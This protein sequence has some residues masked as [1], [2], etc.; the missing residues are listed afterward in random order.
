MVNTGADILP[1]GVTSV[2]SSPLR[3]GTAKTECVHFWYHMGGVDPGETPAHTEKHQTCLKNDRKTQYDVYVR[4]LQ[5]IWQYMWRWW[6][7]RGWRSS[8]TV[9]TRETS[10]AMATETSRL[11]LW[12]GRY[13][14]EAGEGR[15]SNYRL[16]KWSVRTQVIS[17]CIKKSFM[18]WLFKCSLKKIFMNI[19]NMQIHIVF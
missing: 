15:W 9:W 8:L 11:A 16:F 3:H 14:V 18:E 7:E 2:L 19:I 4:G 5:V 12:T 17:L 1:S 10:G 6:T 13:C